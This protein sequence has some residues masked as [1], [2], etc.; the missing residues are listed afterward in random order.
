[1]VR[2]ADRSKVRREG[3]EG[4]VTRDDDSAHDT[5]MAVRNT[6]KLGSSLLFTW[7]IALAMRFWLPRRLGPGPFGTLSFADA[8]ST[9]FFIAL[10][11]GVDAYVLKE[12]AVRPACAS[13][14]F[15]GTLA[16]RAAMWMILLAIMTVTMTA[17]GRPPEVQR[18]VYVFSVARLFVTTNTTLSVCLQA[19]GNVG[20]MSVLAVATKIIWALGAVLAVVADVGL[21]GVALAFL[22]SEAV[23]S[24][25]LFRLAGRH[26]GLVLRMDVAATREVVIL[27][28]PIY[29]N[30]LTMTAYGK[31]DVTLLTLA[32][33]PD[34]AGWYAAASAIASLALLVAPLMSSVVMPTL[35]RAAARSHEEL[36]ARI[37]GVTEFILV[38][39]IPAALFIDLGADLGVRLLFGEAFAP[40]TLALRLLAPIFVVTYVA[41]ILSTT[42]FMLGRTWTIAVISL[43]GL[44]VNVTLNLTLVRPALARLGAGGGGAG[45]VVATLGTELFVTAVMAWFVGRRAFDLRIAVAVGKSL[46]AC[47]L[48][49][50]VDRLAAPLGWARLGLDAIVYVTFV[51]ITGTVRPEWVT[52]VLAAARRR[53]APSGEP[54]RRRG[55]QDAL[56]NAAGPPDI[57]A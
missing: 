30:H 6:L 37:R 43:G 17:M 33:G 44:V 49:V 54:R 57:R 20:S 51:V 1:M 26:L 19:K 55:V 14:L 41:S 52:I 45:C 21:W 7:S 29:L 47:A 5:R 48:V 3:A 12:V 28:L 56:S 35:A 22:V 42:L 40:A 4:A 53:R 46:T 10:S 25:I 15:G 11:L 2:I 31:L 24:V 9:T 13:D 38:I 27:S 32:G 18:V 39:A 8:F 36:F 23:E 16:I 34:E 50:G